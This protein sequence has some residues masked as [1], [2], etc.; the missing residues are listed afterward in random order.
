[1]YHS[2]INYIIYVYLNDSFNVNLKCSRVGFLQVFNN[3]EKLYN[4]K[5]IN[6]TLEHYIVNWKYSIYYKRQVG[7]IALHRN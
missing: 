6:Y 1:M 5:S 2:I 7:S 4:Q 3:L